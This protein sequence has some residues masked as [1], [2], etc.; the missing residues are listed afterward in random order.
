MHIGFLIKKSVFFVHNCF[1]QIR[2][3][4]KSGWNESTNK[5]VYKVLS[6]LAAT[7]LAIRTWLLLTS[8]KMFSTNCLLLNK[9]SS[10]QLVLYPYYLSQG[11]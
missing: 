3:R 4:V 5:G 8:I 11:L 2:S 9:H 6:V 1:R 7:A 10:C